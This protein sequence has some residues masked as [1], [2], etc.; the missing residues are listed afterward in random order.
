M[1]VG[2][3][4]RSKV[5]I[6]GWSSDEAISRSIILGMFS[7]FE[8][9]NP[10]VEV[11]AEGIPYSRIQQQ[12]LLRVRSKDVP[13]LGQIS[14]RWLPGFVAQGALV[15]LNTVFTVKWLRDRIDP[16][17]LKVGQVKGGSTGCPGCRA[18][19]TSSLTAKFWPM[20]A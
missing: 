13:D 15:D 4:A 2:Q 3:A 20:R 12:L 17:L 6:A 8:K 18:P 7:S 19:S 16:A 1:A 10:N 9:A 14:E 11:V 5:V